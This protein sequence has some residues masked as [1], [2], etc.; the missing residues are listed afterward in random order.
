MLTKG[1]LCFYVS[2]FVFT[3][4]YFPILVVCVYSC[5]FVNS[6]FGPFFDILFEFQEMT[7]EAEI[8]STR[9][10]KSVIKSCATLSYVEAQAR[11]DDSC[12]MDPLTTDLRNMNVL[13]KV[14]RQRRIDRG[15]LTLASAE[16]KF[17]IDTETHDPL[18][19]ANQMVEEFILAA[20]ISVAAKILEHFPPCSLLRY[21]SFFMA[22]SSC[23]LEYYICILFF[24][25]SLF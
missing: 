25:V 15:A 18:D 24:F 6:S 14:M 20:N 21:M 1:H 3:Y 8:I 16:V 2:V 4:I 5:V 23:L 7:P 9:F 13:A 17:Q 22:P 19:I 12:L 10:S 11:M